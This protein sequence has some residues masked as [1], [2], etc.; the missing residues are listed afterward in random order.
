ML[1]VMVLC[2]PLILLS[3]LGYFLIW[4]KR[5]IFWVNLSLFVLIIAGFLQFILALFR[6]YFLLP[7]KNAN[8]W[9]TQAKEVF[10][11]TEDLRRKYDYIFLSK[12]IDNIEYAYEVYGKVDPRVVQKQNR[13]NPK[14]DG[15]WVRNFD[16]VYIIDVPK[17]YISTFLSNRSG[18]YIF[19][20][21]FDYFKE[22]LSDYKV[23]NFRL[24]TNPVLI[25]ESL[26][27][28]KKI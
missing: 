9:S 24:G 11:L 18:S 5:R 4:E 7:Y 23:I 27:N 13:E 10:L 2:F 3:S 17:D 28:E 22:S 21:D 15:F 20:G 26:K 14:M 25:K 12:S 8:L 6:L 16:N 19:I 1:Y